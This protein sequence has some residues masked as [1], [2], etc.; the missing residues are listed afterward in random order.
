VTTRPLPAQRERPN[1]LPAGTRIAEFQIT[2]LIGEGGFGIVYRA[3]DT[4]L[5]RDVALKEFMPAALAGRVHG[6][7]R[8][9]IRSAE[10]QAKFEGGL[11][12]FAKE[13]RL[14]AQFSHPSL[15]K[16]YRLLEANATA[17][18]VM[19]FYPGQ[20]LAQRMSSLSAGLDEA[21]IAQTIL[22][23]L[24]A[25]ELLHQDQVFHRDV[26]P[27]N[28]VLSESGAVLLDFGSARQIVGDSVQAITAV[29]KPTYSPVEQYITDGSMRQG[30]WTD[31]YAVGAVLYHLATGKPPVQ[32]VSRLMTD[33]ML[34]VRDR[35]GNAYS[36][37]FS[38][39]VAQAMAVTTEKRLQSI[40]ALRCA[41]GWE[42]PTPAAP[43]S[44]TG[45][46]QVVLSEPAKPNL[47]MQIP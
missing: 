26:S 14:L 21:K 13:A 31:V 32:A 12:S 36:A 38:D 47:A 10:H 39:A 33:S 9:A 3:Y 23:V 6:G 27:D 42:A 11:R 5:Q 44:N 40:Q 20:T 22:P 4:A 25:L 8:V 45:A 35:T 2:D 43:A 17:Y 46:K 29:L 1:C 37:R 19:R 7:T 16:V 15:V 34:T 18:M 24:N 41:L 28:I 30:A